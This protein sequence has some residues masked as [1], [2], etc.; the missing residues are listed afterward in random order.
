[1]GREI[2]LFAD[3]HQKEN[4]LTNYCGLLMKLLYEDS[5]RRFEELLATLLKADMSIIIGPRFTQQI[6]AVKSI[7]DLAIT[8]KSFSI[9]FETKLSDWFYEDQIIRHIE[10]FN[11]SSE[12]KILFL[13]SNFENDNLEEKFEKQIA[14]AKKH[15]VIIQPIS[16]EDFVGSLE[17]VCITEYL[18][19][20]L[21]EF[22]IYLDKNEV[23]PKWKYLLDVVNCSGSLNEIKQNVYMC[24]DTGGAYNHRRAKYFGAYAHKKVAEIFEI[25]AVVVFDK[26]LSN[27]RINWKNEVT[28]NDNTIVELAKN[29]VRT[30]QGRIDEN[31]T[32]PLQVFLLDNRQETNFIKESS[33]GMLQS[34]KY[35]WDIASDCK[36]AQDLAK[37]LKD[38]KWSDFE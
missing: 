5:P 12:D 2:S 30:W 24:P 13:L 17:Q 9:F 3:Y 22:K 23:L 4:S 31:K 37:K 36:N 38:K 26:N 34:K 11:E 6:K 35:F 27:V 28:V 20:L 19:N 8:Q 10:G 21:D 14:D 15:K 18:K 16:F 33:G 7:P 25:K 1:M 29:S 32:V